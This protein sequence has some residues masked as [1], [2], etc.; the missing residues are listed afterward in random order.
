MNKD[1]ALNQ[2]AEENARVVRSRFFAS[3]TKQPGS[4]NKENN[5]LYNTTGE[6]ID[7]GTVAENGESILENDTA[8]RVSSHKKVY[9]P[10]AW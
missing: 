1:C 6:I 8:L 3:V 2:D 7:D 5:T 4:M 9:V 10:L